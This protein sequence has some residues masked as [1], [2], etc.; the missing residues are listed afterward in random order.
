V[1]AAAASLG[2]IKKRGEYR[3]ALAFADTD[4]LRALDAITRH[5]PQLIVLESAFAATSRG[6]ALINRIKADPSLTGCEI[7]VTTHDLQ[8][9]SA[10]PG[11]ASEPLPVPPAVAESSP[12]IPQPPAPPAAPQIEQPVAVAAADAPVAVDAAGTRW[13]PRFEIKDG[14]EMTIDGVAAKVIDVSTSGVQLMA[15]TKL[16]PGQRVRLTVP[17]T[18][19]RVNA[20]VAWAI[21]E[22]PQGKIEYRAGV[23]FVDAYPADI[24]QF[25]DAHKK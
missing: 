15:P 17:G 5:R 4:A 9:D 2:S 21:F 19:L 11:P 8:A 13:A 18:S 20:S 25:I 1:I 12:A 7:Q 22:M 3:D 24:Q 16:K 14:V 10:E 23:A 6:T